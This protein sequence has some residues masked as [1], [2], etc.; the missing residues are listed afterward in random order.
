M[1]GRLERWSESK[2]LSATLFG[3]EMAETTFVNVYVD[4]SNVFHEGQRFALEKRKEPRDDF[5]IYFRHFVDLALRKRKASEIV[6]GGSVPPNNDDVWSYL[7]QLGIKPDLIPR[8]TG[9]ENETVDHQIQLKM[10]RHARKY[11]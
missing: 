3:A 9:G 8:G 6:W 7:E 11:G 4:N 1:A 2:N 10:Y 5:R